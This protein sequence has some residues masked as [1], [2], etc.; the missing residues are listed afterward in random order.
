MHPVLKNKLRKRT[1]KYRHGYE[2]LETRCVLTTVSISGNTLTIVGTPGDDDVALRSEESLP[3]EIIVDTS[4]GEMFFDAEGIAR[5]EFYGLSGID[6]FV[7]TNDS[8]WELETVLF[9]GG[10]GNDSLSVNSFVDA[11]G[12]F[13]EGYGGNGNDVLEIQISIPVTTFHTAEFYGGPGKDTLIGGWLSDHLV[14]GPGADF[15]SGD[16]GADSI[17]G[18]DGADEI[19]G[20]EGND[21]INGGNHSDTIRGGTSLI[22]SDSLSSIPD[23]F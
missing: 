14:G 11:P 22:P 7:P 20:G 5:V 8:S 21:V 1:L 17:F 3:G 15:L 10:D 18:G 23:K 13:I 16:V 12:L 4:D 6:N 2:K 19:D 9:V